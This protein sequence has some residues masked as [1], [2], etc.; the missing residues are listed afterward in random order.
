M[1][2]LEEAMVT[3]RLQFNERYLALRQLK[4]DIIFAVRRDNQR[5]R[6]STFVFFVRS[7]L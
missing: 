5:I 2:L 6:Y 4:K 3:M 1:A 7:H